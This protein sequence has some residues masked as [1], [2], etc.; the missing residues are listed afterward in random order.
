MWFKNVKNLEW[1]KKTNLPEPMIR[2][3]PHA[4]DSDGEFYD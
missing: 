3:S 2:R 4:R 1:K